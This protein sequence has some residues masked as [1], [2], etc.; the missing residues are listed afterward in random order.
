MAGCVQH[1]A[2]TLPEEAFHHFPEHGTA[3]IH[4]A[5]G[6][7]NI[8]YDER[9]AA[10]R[11]ARR[12]DGVVRRELR[13]R[14]QGRRDRR[15]VPL[16]DAQE[17]DRSVQAPA[18]DPPRR[19]ARRRSA[20]NLRAKFGLLFDELG[21]A[22]TRELV[23]RH[24]TPVAVPRPLPAALGGGGG[25]AVTAGRIG[26]R[27]RRLRRVA[28]VSP[29]PDELPQHRLVGEADQPPR[30]GRGQRRERLEPPVTSSSGP[31]SPTR[32]PEPVHR[33]VVEQRE[34]GED[35]LDGPRVAADEDLHAAIEALDELRGAR[36]TGRRGCASSGSASVRRRPRASSTQ[37]SMTGR[38]GSVSRSLRASATRRNHSQWSSTTFQAVAA[39]PR[40][41]ERRGTS[42]RSTGPTPRIAPAPGWPRGGSS[43]ARGAPRARTAGRRRR[44]GS[45]GPWRSTAP[46]PTR[47]RSR[48][49]PPR[50]TAAAPRRRSSAPN[51]L[52]T[53]ACYSVARAGLRDAE[54]APARRPGLRARRRR[55]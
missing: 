24:V 14:A 55:V 45:P 13:R 25:R 43:R 34:R 33:R 31:S 9:R 48:P 4:L 23:E 50:T 15:A 36:R 38:T 27:G 41:P 6:F 16:Q 47:R 1:G 35:A 8:L 21:I 53:R 42:A 54:E 46:R 26:L 44:A 11:A 12:D 19:E 29:D 40:W 7:Q 52:L 22:G 49:R 32:R 51:V 3:E 30:G 18:L 5:T 10:G 28:A 2:S 17:G 39:G 20:R 37:R